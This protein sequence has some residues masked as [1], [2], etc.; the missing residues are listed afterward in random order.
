MHSDMAAIT[1]P[2]FSRMITPTLVEWELLKT[3]PSKFALKGWE[4]RGHQ[5]S[6]EV[7]MG[8]LVG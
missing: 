8:V 6:V 5:D 3:A 1:S 4:L 2:F 7:V